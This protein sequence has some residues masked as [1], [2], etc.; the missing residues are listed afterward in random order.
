MSGPAAVF[1]DHFCG[2]DGGFHGD[3]GGYGGGFVAADSSW[4]GLHAWPGWVG[5]YGG[6]YVYG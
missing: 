2:G 1:I 3:G 5:Y 6:P 4:G